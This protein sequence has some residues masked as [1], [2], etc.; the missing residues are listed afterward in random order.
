MS[1]IAILCVGLG[2]TSFCLVVAV[3]ALYRDTF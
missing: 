1:V 3:C 2:L